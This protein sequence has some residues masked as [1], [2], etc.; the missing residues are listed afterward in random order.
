MKKKIA[1]EIREIIHYDKDTPS[2]RRNYQR[3]KSQYKKLSCDQ[4]K[5]DFLKMLNDFYNTEEK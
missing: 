1:K 5:K 3:A 4:S 2:S